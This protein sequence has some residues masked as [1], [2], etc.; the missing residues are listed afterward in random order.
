MKKLF[1]VFLAALLTFTM[2]VPALATEE[3]VMK[4]EGDPVVIVRGIDFGG[5]VHGDGSKALQFKIEDLLDF[6]YDFAY[7]TVKG[8]DDAF[9]TALLIFFQR[10][11]DPIAS[12]NE[13]KSVYADVHMETYPYPAGEIEKLQEWTEGEGGLVQTAVNTFGGENVYYFTYDWR[14]SPLT[15]SDELNAFIEMVKKNTGKEKVDIGAC[16]MG[17]MV[18]TAYMYEYGTES[19]DSLSYLSA[20]HN[21]TD[22]AGAAL[23]GDIYTTGSFLYNYL[24]NMIG[25]NLILNVLMK[26]LDTAKVFDGVAD[27][28]NN[29][30][31][32]NKDRVYDEL[33][34]DYL[35]TSLGFWGLCC[36]KDFDSSVEF[37]FGKHKDE[38]PVVMSE[39]SKIRDFL[40]STEKV[41]DK[42]YA[43]GVKVSFVSH[44]GDMLLPIYAETVVESDSILESYLTS[45][46]ATFALFGETLADEYISKIDAKYISPDKV[47]DV[48]TALYKDTTWIIKD[49]PHVGG[50]VGSE[51]SDFVMW[52]LSRE[53][54]P[55]VTDD[56]AYPRFMAVDDEMNFIR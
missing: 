55:T 27:F 46:G 17:G 53:T 39:L 1:S 16:S 56:S 40:F 23:T 22:V 11:F 30:V 45:N 33:M 6:L 25:D 10:L 26:A 32:K 49:A 5:L 2:C 7:D 34:R 47:V 37:V 50:K 38:Y 36:D 24:T 29:F 19:I 8:E 20:A 28:L 51:H 13:G 12:D 35:G 48:S 15:L 43:D 31:A 18:A 41:I 9:E 4:Y 14:K 44:Y 52:L 54:Q 3:T 42:A 21:G